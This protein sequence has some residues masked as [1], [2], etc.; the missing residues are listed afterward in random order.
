MVIWIRN[1]HGTGHVDSEPFNEQ[2][3]PHDLNTKLV[4]F[5][6]IP[7]VNDRFQGEPQAF[8]ELGP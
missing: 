5:I 2:K 1:Y 7:T 8:I 6:Q 3:I 4:F